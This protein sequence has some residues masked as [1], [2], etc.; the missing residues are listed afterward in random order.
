[1]HSPQHGRNKYVGVV[2][3]GYFCTFTLLT[4]TTTHYG[5]TFFHY[6][7]VL[8]VCWHRMGHHT[9][10]CHDIEKEE[11]FRWVECPE[12]AY[13]YGPSLRRRFV[14]PDL[15]FC[16][17][18]DDGH[19]LHFWIQCGWRLFYGFIVRADVFISR[20]DCAVLCGNGRRFDR[21]WL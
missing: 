10:H 20:L 5:N 7:S 16:F 3:N 8:V 13:R 18:F 1:M 21:R 17:Y 2:G 11:T 15:P 19:A 6:C 9:A 12:I 4:S 14:L